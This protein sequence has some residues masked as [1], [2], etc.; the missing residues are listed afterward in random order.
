MQYLSLVKQ[1]GQSIVVPTMSKVYSLT[2]VQ[3]INASLDEVW[4][5]FSV[6]D[7]L[8]AI[9]PNDM[10]FT[11]LSKPHG[12]KVYAGQ[13]LEYK[14]RPLLN[15][16][17]YWMT[18]ITHV[19]DK[20]FF[21]DEQRFGPFSLWHHQHHFKQTDEGVEMTDIIHYKLPM[22]FLGDIANALMVKKQLAHIF[23]YRFEKVK[24]LFNK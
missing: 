20:Q 18:E 5:F 12:D 10:G 8:Q 1:Y 22:W 23:D 6:A 19:A 17:F 9:T 16:P 24:T 15:I 21:V 7:N 14:V 11:I 4:S 2:K 13:I 3:V